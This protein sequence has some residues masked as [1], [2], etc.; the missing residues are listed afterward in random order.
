MKIDVA[1]LLDVHESE[2]EL[3]LLVF[4]SIAQHIHDACKSFARHLTVLVLRKAVEYAVGEERVLPL[5]K[6][7]HLLPELFDVHHKLG[8]FFHLSVL[9]LNHDFDLLGT[10]PEVAL[11]LFLL[12]DAEAVLV[13]YL[14]D[15]VDVA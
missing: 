13:A 15:E 2:A 12:R 6:E 9:V 10:F 5:S 14:V 3:V 7:A 11:Q 8:C 4:V 1:G